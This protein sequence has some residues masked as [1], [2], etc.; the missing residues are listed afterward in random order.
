MTE[1]PTRRELEDEV[2]RGDPFALM[3]MTR[4]LLAERDAEADEPRD[5]DDYGPVD[6]YG[7]PL[8]ER[9]A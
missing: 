1:K 4:Q 7:N 9:P 8:Y 6:P 2:I 3:P 5:G